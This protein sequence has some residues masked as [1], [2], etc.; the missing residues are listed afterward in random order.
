MKNVRTPSG[1]IIT[2]ALMPAPQSIME[3]KCL[4]LC[5]KRGH[6]NLA[7]KTVCGVRVAT[8]VPLVSMATSWTT[9]TVCGIW[10]KTAVDG[11]SLELTKAYVGRVSISSVCGPLNGREMDIVMDPLDIRLILSGPN[12]SRILHVLASTR[13][14][15]H[16][17]DQT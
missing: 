11:E 15:F 14:V 6:V 10:R 2:A 3:G 5:V 1:Y 8:L 13:K 16:A 17:T 7:R 4:V 12:T 9:E